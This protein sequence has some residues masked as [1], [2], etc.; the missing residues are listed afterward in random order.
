MEVVLSPSAHANSPQLT[1]QFQPPN[2]NCSKQMVQIESPSIS[3]F[4]MYRCWS[5]VLFNFQSEL[6]SIRL[7][8]RCLKSR[9]PIA[10]GIIVIDEPELI[11]FVNQGLTL[12]TASLVSGVESQHP[13]IRGTLN[14]Q[15]NWL[16]QT[17]N[18]TLRAWSNNFVKLFQC[19]INVSKPSLGSYW[20]LISLRYCYRS[21][22]T[23]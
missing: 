18:G 1:A 17:T 2:S 14:L 10:I 7:L 22:P 3:K 20:H 19:E 8:M 23:S 13:G 12:S 11:L 21:E 15:V 5:Q 6:E 16:F 9:F 4:Q